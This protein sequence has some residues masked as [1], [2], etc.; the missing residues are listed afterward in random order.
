MQQVL[1]IP[2]ANPGRFRRYEHGLLIRNAYQTMDGRWFMLTMHDVPRYW[3]RLCRALNRPDWAADGRFQTTASMLAHGAE[4]MRD[5]EAA[6]R[7]HDLEHWSEQFDAAGCVWAPAATPH[8]VAR[9]GQLRA[10]GAFATL[11][12]A[13]DQRTR[14]C[15]RRSRSTP[16]MC[17]PGR[18]RH[19]SANTARR[20][21]ARPTSAIRKPPTLPP[22]RSSARPTRL[23]G[24]VPNAKAAP[25]SPRCRL[26]G[27]PPAC[28][29]AKRPPKQT[30]TRASRSPRDVRSR[31]RGLG[32][33]P[34]SAPP[35]ARCTRRSWP[36]ASG[37]RAGSPSV[38]SG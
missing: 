38:P 13:D 37:S 16:R 24:R 27:V 22:T 25:G 7:E 1:N 31:A 21:C 2:G 15:R 9:D 34:N 3:P 19:S 8:E 23:A 11:L 29:R 26:R 20:S 18:A 14:W 4:L 12:D 32:Q 30:T 36:L 17:I 28:A 10:T 33:R 35:R 5:L 6:F